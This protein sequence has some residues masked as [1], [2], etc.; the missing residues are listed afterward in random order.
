MEYKRAQDGIAVYHAMFN[1]FY[2]GGDLQTHMTELETMLNTD[3]D[4]EYPGGPL[5]YL[6]DWEKA[7]VKLKRV[8]PKEDWTD[9]SLRRKFSQRFSV[10]GYTDTICDLCLDSTTTWHQFV[11]SLRRKLVRK[12]FKSKNTHKSNVHLNNTMLN[13]D[14]YLHSN[15][16]QISMVN[17]VAVENQTYTMEDHAWFQYYVKTIN[18]EG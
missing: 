12:E 16:N 11:D 17:N 2:Y 3:L 5:Q 1:K 18:K 6:N 9:S 13:T 15:P 7:A 4:R 8:T 10:L 14:N